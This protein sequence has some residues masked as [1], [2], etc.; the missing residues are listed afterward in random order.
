MGAAIRTAVQAFVPDATF[1]DEVAR[2]F[3]AGFPRLFR[4]LHRLTGDADLAADLAQEAFVR[5]HSRGSMPDE[6]SAWLISVALNQFRNTR[7]TGTRRRRLLTT[8][9]AEAVMADAAAVPG[10]EL[11]AEERRA[12]VR[13]ALDRL[14]ERDRQLLLLHA[15]SYRYRE[16]AAALEL[17]ESSIGTL[18]ARAKRA[19]LEASEQ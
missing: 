19:F 17:N 1:S 13:R 18:L 11:E 2:A 5:L 16:I 6:P 14:T 10:V 4:F 12:Q 8:F 3:T 7:T 15:E 9:R